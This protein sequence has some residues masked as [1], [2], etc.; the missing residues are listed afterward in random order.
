[1]GKLDKLLG[2]IPPQERREIE[3]IIGKI[4]VRDL[5]GLDSKKLKGLK[6]IFRVRK[7]NFR[8]IFEFRKS[9]PNILTIE[10][11]GEHTYNL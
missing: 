8:I 2:K 4:L 6:N 10:R 11:C 9:E 1:M 5:K 7:G 3:H